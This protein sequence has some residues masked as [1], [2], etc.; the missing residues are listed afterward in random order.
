MVPF[1]EDVS[2]AF[3]SLLVGLTTSRFWHKVSRK[4]GRFSVG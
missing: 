1:G 3:L 2:G 4:D